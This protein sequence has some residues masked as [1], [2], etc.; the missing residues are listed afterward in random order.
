MRL[1]TVTVFP[2][3]VSP[4]LPQPLQPPPPVCG[5]SGFQNQQS[6]PVLGG[7]AQDAQGE[8]GSH[9]RLLKRGGAS[10]QLVVPAEPAVPGEGKAV[11]GPV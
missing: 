2:V 11:R 1:P 3:P 4:P 7:A 8:P 9:A 6:P 5:H 10:G